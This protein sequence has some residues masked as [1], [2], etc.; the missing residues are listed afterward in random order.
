MSLII[1]R[2]CEIYW[3]RGEQWLS[4][5]K[6]LSCS[7]KSLGY[8]FFQCHL[9]VQV[10]PRQPLTGRS[11][12]LCNLQLTPQGRKGYCQVFRVLVFVKLSE[13]LFWAMPEIFPTAKDKRSFIVW[14]KTERD[15]LTVA[16]RLSTPLEKALYH[17]TPCPA[18][19]S[20]RSIK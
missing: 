19:Q 1:L 6:Q 8:V 9:S 15:M 17:L 11:A 16:I 20:G 10:F 5:T 2:A 14:D 12:R 4:H 7:Y 18:R 13:I 3:S